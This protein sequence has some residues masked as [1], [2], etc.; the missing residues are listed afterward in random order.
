M[1]MPAYSSYALLPGFV[2]D[3]VTIIM[4]THE[5]WSPQV[6]SDG[7]C[8]LRPTAS[9]P[10][11]DSSPFVPPKKLLIP[12]REK[13]WNYLTGQFSLPQAP[14]T[15]AIL[16]VA[17][18]DLQAIWYL[19]QVFAGDELYAAR[20]AQSL[21]IGISCSPGPECRCDSHLMPLA[22]DVFLSLDRAWA[23][24][25]KGDALLRQS[26]CQSPQELPLPWPTGTATKRQTITAEQLNSSQNSA[27]FSEAAKPC[28]SCGA[29]SVVC[30][31]CYCFDLLDDVGLD[32]D[33][34]RSRVWDN[35]FFAEHGKVAGGHDFR[36]GRG[37]RLRFRLEHKYLGFGDLLGQN[38]C[39]GCGRCRSICP[40][41]IDLDAVAVQL[42]T[43]TAR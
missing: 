8:R 34:S 41:D 4:E 31:T 37:A 13:I 43:E 20:R 10:F 18:C 21:L 9:L 30:P 2:D 25:A 1:V 6:D 14:Q 16:G 36:A 5:L 15:L 26:G 27:C 38:S 12:P 28:L 33:V 32:G 39:V 19:D 17:L 29:C 40:V 42:V 24:S 11:L 3:F 22:G 35:C 7:I 23:L